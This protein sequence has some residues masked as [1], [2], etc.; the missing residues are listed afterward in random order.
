MSTEGFTEEIDN[1]YVVTPE[2]MNITDKQMAQTYGVPTL[3]L[4][5]NAGNAIATYV[6]Q[7]Y[8]TDKRILIITGSGNNGGDG[9]SAARLLHAKDCDVEVVSLCKSEM[10]RELVLKNYE[11]ARNLGVK[12]TL[13]ADETEIAARI[14]ACDI[15]VDAI[16]GTGITGIV[17]AEVA[18]VIEL[19]NN[20]DKHVISVDVPSGINATDGSICGAAV[21]ADELIVLGTL[22]QGLL[23][24]PARSC[25]DNVIIDKISIPD[26]V[27]EGVSCK[28]VFTENE[29]SK[30]FASRRMDSHKGTFGKLGIIAGSVG[31]TG[32]ACLSAQAAL[33]S[34]AGIIQLAVPQSLN[35]IFEV[36]LTE[37]MT[38]PMPENEQ[39]ALA[40]SRELIDFCDGKTALVIGPGISQGSQGQLFIPDI[41]HTFSGTV[42]IDADGLNLIAKNPEVLQ[43]GKCVVTPHLGEMSRLTGLTVEQI[44]ANQAGTALDFA[45]KYNTVVVLKSYVTVI[46]SPDG[47]V[48]FNVTGNS[49]MAT[50]GSGDVLSGIIGSLAA[51]GYT[52]FEAAVIGA[53]V[54]G[55]AAD[56]AC[57]TVSQ[58]SLCPSDTVE[59]LKTV[60]KRITGK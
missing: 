3:L 17:K 42:V 40:R 11:M 46:A 5:E 52:A 51:Q 38:C 29:I 1:M 41:L 19:I 50:G 31:M 27:F 24:Y 30:L 49:G 35:P 39:G 55:A 43:C 36:K 25:F 37:Q 54:N 9:W 23:Y 12:Y 15:I 10:M 8:G 57:E 6:Y 7:K 20:A 59:S 4:M 47:N 44:A 33:R 13:D 26:S 14:A 56:T 2:E 53:F 18:R 32:A 58:I 45:K 22:K 28:R 21:H 34:G 48:V 16:L 60:F